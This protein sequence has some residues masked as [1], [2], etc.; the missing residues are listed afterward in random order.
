VKTKFRRQHLPSSP[1]LQINDSDLARL[2]DV[3]PSDTVH[4]ILNRHKL[5]GSLRRR[6][7]RAIRLRRRMLAEIAGQTHTA[8]ELDEAGAE[9][10]RMCSTDTTEGSE[11]R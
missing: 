2:Y 8:Q 1:A 3:N 5:H 4:Q 11:H 9:I 7:S 6:V 10:E